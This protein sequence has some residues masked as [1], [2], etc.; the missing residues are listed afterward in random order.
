MSSKVKTIGITSLVWMIAISIGTIYASKKK[1]HENTKYMEN[2]LQVNLITDKVREKTG[3][4]GIFLV[5]FQRSSPDKIFDFI[6]SYSAGCTQRVQA[7][8]SL[9]NDKVIIK[10]LSL[11]H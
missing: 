7:T 1:E 10:K 9:K 6:A 11:L 5:E 8:G 3:N 4:K 2:K